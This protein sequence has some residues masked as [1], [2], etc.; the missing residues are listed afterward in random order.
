MSGEFPE[1]KE[2]R[3]ARWVAAFCERQAS[4][5]GE[6]PGGRLPTAAEWNLFMARRENHVYRLNNWG[7]FAC[8]K[9]PGDGPGSWHVHAAIER[10]WRGR[11]ALKGCKEA[12]RRFFEAEPGARELWAEHPAAA[13]HVTRFCAAGGWEVIRPG[14]A[15]ARRTVES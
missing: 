12:T 4:V 9:M 11:W 8:L 15:V 6:S 14:L 3:D 5:D 7:V 13:R 2:T 1:V 10:R